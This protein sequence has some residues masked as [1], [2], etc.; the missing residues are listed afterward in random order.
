MLDELATEFQPVR[1]VETALIERVAIA[2][3]RQRRLVRAEAAEVGLNYR[4]FGPD[5][6]KRVGRHL[7]LTF[8][9]CD[10]IAAPPEEEEP[11]LAVLTEQR[12]FWQGLIDGQVA[13]FAAPFAAL[14]EAVRN[15]LLEAHGGD[16]DQI[17]ATITK[18]HG[19][20]ARWFI[21]QILYG[22]PKR[23]VVDHP[24]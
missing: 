16:A 9:Q 5:Q 8:G 20:W 7:N 1:L 15:D 24:T 23:E 22:A 2:F 4:S 3:W 10:D 17:A 13:E 14:P 6:A 21:D 11:S 18:Q 19:S 12:A